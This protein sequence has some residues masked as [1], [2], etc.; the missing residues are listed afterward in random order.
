M[1]IVPH[2]LRLGGNLETLR[3][4][5]ICRSCIRFYIAIHCRGPGQDGGESDD[6]N[7]ERLSDRGQSKGEAGGGHFKKGAWLS[8]CSA[9]DTPIPDEGSSDARGE[10]TYNQ[11]STANTACAAAAVGLSLWFLDGVEERAEEGRGVLT[12]VGGTRS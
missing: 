8:L 9:I 7:D 3:C 2:V 6:D 4:V 11:S 1:F 10:T 12:R 5:H